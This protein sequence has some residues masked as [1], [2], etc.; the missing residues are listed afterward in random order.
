[1]MGLRASPAGL[2]ERCLE[3]GRDQLIEFWALVR[4]LG[5]VI[6]RT[7]GPTLKVRGGAAPMESEDA[8]RQNGG[9]LA[10][11]LAEGDGAGTEWDEDSSEG[12]SGGEASTA[13]GTTAAERRRRPSLAAVPSGY[14][15]PPVALLEPPV[16]GTTAMDTRAL[17]EGSK[18]LEEKLR[19]FGVNGKVQKVEPGPVVSMFE[20]EPA[21]GVKI[22][23]VANLA[24]DLALAMR[25]GAVRIVAPIP[26]KG[27]VGIEIP[28]PKRQTV[29]LRE[30]LE[31]EGF[32]SATSPLTLAL[33]KDITGEPVSADLAKMP[34]LLV[35]GATGSGKSVALNAMIL[36][37][38]A[39]AT[40]REVRLLLIDP[41]VL[42]F[43]CYNDVPHLIAPVVTDAKKAKFAL[44]WAVREMEHRYQRLAELGV[45]NLEAYNNKLTKGGKQL[46]LELGGDPPHQPMPFLVVVVDELADLMMVAAKEVEDSIARL[47]QMARAAGIHL[48]VATQR[49]SVDVITG[50]IKANFSTRIAFQVTQRVDSRTILDTGGAEHLLGQG[51]MLYLP[52]GSAKV[53][54]I[55][56]PLVTDKEI[57]EVV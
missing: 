33:G 17:E 45:R 20:F 21:P 12:E 28:N 4:S 49:P 40:P 1:M 25:C 11:V 2:V 14:E 38:M 27:V 8:N 26:G 57:K 32:R 3:W 47:A 56:G 42:E 9:T 53:I 35:A 18:L 30:I 34:H 23:Q 46:Q 29:Y 6:R 51:D 7:A 43:S 54:R 15:M 52:P 22:S 13:D 55:H 41:K 36:S 39:R 50:T 16:D 37:L 19:D 5:G 24:D 48:I 10:Q 31:S 44:M